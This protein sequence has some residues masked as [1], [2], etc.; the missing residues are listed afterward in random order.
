MGNNFFIIDLINGMFLMVPIHK[1]IDFDF[2]FVKSIKPNVFY[3]KK[4]RVHLLF[5]L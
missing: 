1:Q 2:T 3:D 4:I 5:Q